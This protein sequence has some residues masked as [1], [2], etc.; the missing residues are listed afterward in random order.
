MTP[1]ND[2]SSLIGFL[3]FLVAIGGIGF[4]AWQ[5]SFGAGLFM[6]VVLFIAMCGL[7]EWSKKR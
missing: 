2:D 4:G 6:L 3:L 7:L 1:K 5:H